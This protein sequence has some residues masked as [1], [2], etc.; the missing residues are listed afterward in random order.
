MKTAAH[1][2]P[3]VIQRTATQ[4]THCKRLLLAHTEHTT[5]RSRRLTAPPRLCHLAGLGEQP[6]KATH[7][8]PLPIANDRDNV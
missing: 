7:T 5:P 2:Q 3:E 6:T 4:M 8:R 1:L